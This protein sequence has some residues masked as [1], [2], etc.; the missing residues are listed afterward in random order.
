MLFIVIVCRVNDAQSRPK[1]EYTPK[2]RPAFDFEDDEQSNG[3]YSPPAT[4][5][6]AYAQGKTICQ[7]LVECPSSL[8]VCAGPIHSKACV[9]E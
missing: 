5:P 1:R 3:G 2:A 6:Q 8:A 7:E 9:R 4:S